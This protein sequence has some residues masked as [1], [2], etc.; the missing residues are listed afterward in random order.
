MNS[1]LPNDIPDHYNNYNLINTSEP[2]YE[3]PVLPTNLMLLAEQLEAIPK[4]ILA[5]QVLFSLELLFSIIGLVLNIVFVCRKKTNFLVRLFVYSSVA[6]TLV[7]AL[8]LAI[9]ILLRP[10]TM[11]CV[12]IVVINF[13]L[14]YT[15]WI[16]VVTSCTAYSTLL[17]KLCAQ[18]CSCCM[19]RQSCCVNRTPKQQVI[20]EVVLVLVTIVL[21]IPVVLGDIL[22]RLSSGLFILASYSA[23]VLFFAIPVMLLTLIGYVILLVWFCVRRRLIAKRRGTAQTILVKELVMWFMYF[24]V[25]ILVIANFVIYVFI[26][27]APS[28][29]GL[30]IVITILTLYP[31]CVL[32][33]MFY[34]FRTKRARHVDNR[35]QED[36]TNLV[37]AHPPKWFSLTTTDAAV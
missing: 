8:S 23:V 11:A 24:I 20:M 2:D 9:I 18:T 19:R 33:Y 16:I 35:I 12:G 34:S 14:A 15:A 30:I 31:Y 7:V 22:G 1:S 21:P 3:C 25:N 17:W 4:L 32:V 13:G 36:G 5:Q 6:T 28:R 26:L 37:T 27:S 10:T 29:I